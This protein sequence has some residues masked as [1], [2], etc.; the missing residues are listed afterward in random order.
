M[1]LLC[2]VINDFLKSIQ[3]CH[4]GYNRSSASIILSKHCDSKL[5]INTVFRLL[6]VI[7]IHQM[8]LL[9]NNKL[10]KFPYFGPS[11]HKAL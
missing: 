4:V 7:F 2:D 9:Q 3:L 8:G 5:K 11:L 10:D 6:L 1:Y